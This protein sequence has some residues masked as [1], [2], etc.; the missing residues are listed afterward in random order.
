MRVEEVAEALALAFLAIKRHVES[1]V[2]LKA[3]LYQVAG[4]RTPNINTLR[5]ARRLL[6]TYAVEE[7]RVDSMFGKFL[8]R[9]S[10][11]SKILLKL[12]ISGLM[13]GLDLGDPEKLAIILRRTLK[14]YWPGDI[15]PWMGI[16]RAVNQG[17]MELPA[18]K[19]Y[20]Q[21]FIKL[22]SKVLGKSEAREFMKFQDE[23]KPATYIVVNF[24]VA[25]ER[26]VLEELE[27]SGAEFEPDPRLPNIYRV[28]AAKKTKKL[29]KFI[30]NGL[31]LVQDFSS[32][33]AVYCA[34][35][36]PEMVVLD[37]CAAPGS[38]TIL[39]GLQMKNRGLIVSID[40]SLERIRTH[41]ERVRR[42]GLSIV[43]DIV[44]DATI[45]LPLSLKADVVLLD[46]PCSSTGL[47]WREPAYRRIIK[48]KHV[49]MFA[50]LQAKMLENSAKHVKENGYLIYSTCSISL[51]ENEILIEDFLKRHPE[52]E[53][54]EVSPALG[55][56]G[57]RGLSE[58]RRLYPHR[59]L[60]NG[61]FI[62]K[63][64]KRW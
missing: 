28:K 35:L 15:E 47:F 41:L 57:L 3:G 1:E 40:S 45:P 21:W 44:A 32:Y 18:S 23:V 16:V 14:K 42:A 2:S 50:K 46:P 19:N 39:M 38:K 6:H 64:L 55:S 60:C 30:K 63:L 17:V 31:L 61:F 34:E 54:A 49:K 29:V 11:D 4:P 10:E 20:P 5:L 48:P 59:D 58:A 36:K 9:N 62:A 27:K 37:V 24:L 43:E 53:L 25:K 52:F 51:E 56:G 13:G 8:E 26:E 12:L 33:Y 22:V 7:N